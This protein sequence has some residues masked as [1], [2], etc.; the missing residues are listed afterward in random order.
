MTR[1]DVLRNL[2]DGIILMELI[3]PNKLLTDMR[4]F[5]ESKGSVS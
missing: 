5:L 4:A 1:I 3:P 2:L